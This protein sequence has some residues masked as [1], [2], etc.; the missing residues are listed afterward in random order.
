MSDCIYSGIDSHRFTPLPDVEV[1]AYCYHPVDVHGTT[2]LGC[3]QCACGM[4]PDYFHPDPPRG[5]E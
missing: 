3:A 4:E 2:E 1:C 5:D